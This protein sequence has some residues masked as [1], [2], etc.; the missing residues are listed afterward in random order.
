MERPVSFNSAG[1]TLRGTLHVP[2]DGGAR[3]PG[4]VTCHG[5]GGSSS[6]AGHPELGRALERA[7]YVVLRFDFRGCGASDGERGRVICLEEV[8]D[9]RNAVTF[10]QAQEGVDPERIGVIGASLGG[11]VA[12]YGAATDQR[13]KL[14][15]ANGAVGNGERFLRFQYPDDAHWQRFLE[16]LEEAKRHRRQTGQSVM[17]PRYEIVFIPE[18]RRAGMPPGAI[19]EFPAETAISLLEF[20]PQSVVRQIAPRPLLLIHPRGDDVVPKSE[21]EQLAA[22]AGGPCELHII[23]TSEHFGS[24]DPVLHRITLE[25]LARYL[26]APPGALSHDD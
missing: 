3:R 18:Q 14:C 24:G 23:E 10:L 6:G 1:A 2:Y 26:M 21:S 16:R 13:L 8:E 4:I 7:G 19:M 9:L 15:A 25:W 5:F 11:A 17:I 12:V 22:A 20:N